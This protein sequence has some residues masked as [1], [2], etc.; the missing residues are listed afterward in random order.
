MLDLFVV[1]LIVLVV[2]GI[3]TALVVGYLV[4]ERDANELHER[5][6]QYYR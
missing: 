3:P 1:A 5:K 6:R 2:I 4:G